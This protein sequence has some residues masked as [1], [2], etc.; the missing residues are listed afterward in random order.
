ML[1]AQDFSA[2]PCYVNRILNRKMLSTQSKFWTINFFSFSYNFH[3][4]FSRLIGDKYLVFIGNNNQIKILDLQ[5]LL[6][7]FPVAELQDIV[8]FQDTLWP[9]PIDEAVLF[10]DTLLPTPIDEAQWKFKV[11]A[12]EHQVAIALISE[13]RG[14]NSDWLYVLDFT[15]NRTF[16]KLTKMLAIAPV[17]GSLIP[18]ESAE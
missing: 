16:T 14:G 3:D 6:S 8:L 18:I 13:R 10:Q 1:P 4:S 15:H 5:L 12:D 11:H 2:L 17:E 9:T 7:S